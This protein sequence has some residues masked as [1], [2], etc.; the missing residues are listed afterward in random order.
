MK[1]EK[2]IHN[3]F[4]RTIIKLD[5][6]DFSMSLGIQTLPIRHDDKILYFGINDVVIETHDFPP[7]ELR[8]EVHL[9]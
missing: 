8:S 6:I 9:D 4:K 5:D 3:S 7:V 1:Q 2:K